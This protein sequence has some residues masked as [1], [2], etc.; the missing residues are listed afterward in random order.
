[1]P[2][3]TQWILWW[4]RVIGAGSCVA[5]A[6]LH[7]TA[8]HH[9]ELMS[10]ADTLTGMVSALGGHQHHPVAVLAPLISHRLVVVHSVGAGLVFPIFRPSPVSAGVVDSVLARQSLTII[11]H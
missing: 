6:L 9:G 10:P 1:M 3:D 8:V 4:S 7:H 11:N 2:T 5:L